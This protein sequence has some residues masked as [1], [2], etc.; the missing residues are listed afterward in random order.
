MD[1]KQLFD[2]VD[3]DIL[4]SRLGRKVKDKRIKR[5]I[6]AILKAGVRDGDRQISS[7]KGTPQGGPLSPLL[8]NI[9]LD[10]LDKEL[11]R[12][13]HNF[14]CYADDCNIH[15]WSR[16]CF[17]QVEN[18]HPLFCP[19][20]FCTKQGKFGEHI[21]T[22]DLRFRSN[23]HAHFSGESQPVLVLQK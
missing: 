16:R 5:L 2:E 15:V 13:G 14:A 18:P 3:H 7:P 8:S 10:E 11:E 19:F 9:L 21:T 12:R 1:L 6:N 23:L 20:L 4:M 17:V 22:Y